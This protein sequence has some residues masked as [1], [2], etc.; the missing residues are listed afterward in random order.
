MVCFSESGHPDNQSPGCRA[1]SSLAERKAHADR[2]VDE[3]RK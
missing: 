2:G 1:G 3:T